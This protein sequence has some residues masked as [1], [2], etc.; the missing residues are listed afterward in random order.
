MTR[1][2]WIALAITL[3]VKIVLG[4][5]MPLSPDEAYYWVWSHHPQLSYFDHPPFVAWLFYLGRSF[6]GFGQLIRLPGILLG[7]LTL[8]IW[9]YMLKDT[10]TP[11]A[12]WAWLALA[13]ACPMTGVG[14]LVVTPDIPLMFFWSLCIFCLLRLLSS[15]KS[16]WAFGL[17]F[18]L[19]LGFISKYTVL[20]FGPFALILWVLAERSHIPLNRVVKWMVIAVPGFLLG[21]LPVIYWNVETRFASVLFQLGHGF[22]H[23]KVNYQWDWTMGYV[24]AQL[25]ILF[26]LTVYHLLQ[27]RPRAPMWLKVFAFG[28]FVFF[29]LTSFR[30]VVEANW[31]AIGYFAAFALALHGST[32]YRWVQITVAVQVL[33]VAVLLTDISFRWLPIR[34]EQLKTREFLKFQKLSSLVK[35]YQPLFA[36][37]YQNAAIL[38]YDSGHMVYKLKGFYRR[39]QGVERPDFYDFRSESDVPRG[40]FNLFV[41]TSDSLPPAVEQSHRIQRRIPVSDEYEIWELVAK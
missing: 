19:G 24:L 11:K 31:P 15:Q 7:Q 23:S 16:L 39:Q 9:I 32:R 1:K 25:G 35:D 13:L 40:A 18:C 34:D 27:S 3:V 4:A 8:I 12:L 21:A 17:G 41:R 29:L 37:T 30:A 6:E 33:A 38:S 26:P 5:I 22:G 28:P 20:L 10:L 2:L 36:S 14:S